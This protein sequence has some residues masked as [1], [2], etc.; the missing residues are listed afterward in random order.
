MKPLEKLAWLLRGIAGRL[1]DPV[2]DEFKEL[3]RRFPGM[4]PAPVCRIKTLRTWDIP[5]LEHH[6]YR[7]ARKAG[8]PA[9][10]RPHS[11]PP[12]DPLPVWETYWEEVAPYL[13]PGMTIAEVGP[14]HGYFTDRYMADCG[15]AYLVDFSEM[16]CFLLLPD[17]YRN[18]PKATPVFTTNCRMPAIPDGSVDLFFSLATFVHIEIETQ[19]GYLLEA[20]R[21]LKKGGTV[22]IHFASML[23]DEAFKSYADMCPADFSGHP[24]RCHHPQSVEL[25]ARRV[26]FQVL[27]TVVEKNN[28]NSFIHLRK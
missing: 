12:R 21:V 1:H 3:E 26:G 17:K 19:Y 5:L 7:K 11:W 8:I 9:E 15:R 14:G 23:G 28:F 6:L 24:L 4:V 18:E 20:H 25:L 22:V 27:K 13:K 2:R 10:Y 16:L